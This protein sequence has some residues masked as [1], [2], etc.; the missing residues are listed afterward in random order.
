MQDE[1]RQTRSPPRHRTISGCG[2]CPVGAPP[3]S[4][5]CKWERVANRNAHSRV[6]PLPTSGAAPCPQHQAEQWPD[7]TIRRHRQFQIR[8]GVVRRCRANLAPHAGQ[9]PPDHPSLM[10]AAPLRAKR[11][12]CFACKYGAT[13]IA[14]A[15]HPPAVCREDA[16]RGAIPNRRSPPIGWRRHYAAPSAVCRAAKATTVVRSP[17]AVRCRTED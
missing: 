3:R 12:Q 15:V 16:H 7:R 5:H 1:D 13:S 6:S 8:A 14:R 2:K 4:P 10:T 9:V 17:R 11:A